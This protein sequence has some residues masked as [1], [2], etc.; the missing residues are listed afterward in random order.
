MTKEKQ[1][2]KSKGDQDRQRKSERQQKRC[3]NHHR[4]ERIN[5]AQRI[6]AQAAEQLRRV[7]AEI[8]RGPAVRDLM[9][10]NGK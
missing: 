8:A 7:I 9:Q 5:V 2:R 6:Q 1:E 10:S 3:G 4:A